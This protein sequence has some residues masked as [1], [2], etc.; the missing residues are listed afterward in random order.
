LVDKDL[1]KPGK[2]RIFSLTGPGGWIEYSVFG[3]A[4]F[5]RLSYRLV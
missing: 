3:G 5:A 4:V 1:W 2:A